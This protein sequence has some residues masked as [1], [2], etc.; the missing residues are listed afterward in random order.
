MTEKSLEK[1]VKASVPGVL[2]GISSSLCSATT[3]VANAITAK[4]LKTP[5][6]LQT[7]LSDLG[8]PVA[9]YSSEIAEK[10]IECAKIAQES[11]SKNTDLIVETVMNDTGLTVSEKVELIYNWEKTKK[12]DQIKRVKAVVQTA[13][14]SFIK[15]ALPIAAVAVTKII[16]DAA[17]A[18]VRSNN[19]AASIQSYSPSKFIEA[20]KK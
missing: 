7:V 18:V 14:D 17:V 3:A 5:L 2:E 10:L 13:T 1:V 19:H 16:A 9:K 4:N 6:L 15:V 12:D 8:E 11:N 20:I